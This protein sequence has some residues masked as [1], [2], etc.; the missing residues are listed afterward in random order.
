[1]S[2]FTCMVVL[3]ER[4]TKENQLLEKALQPFHEFECTGTNDEYVQEIDK[5]PEAREAFEKATAVLILQR[6]DGTKFHPFNDSGNWVDEVRPF[7]VEV[8]GKFNKQLVLPEGWQELRDEPAKEWQDFAAWCKGEYGGELIV[9]NAEPDKDGAHKYGW[10]RVVDG[11]VAELIDRTNPNKK[12]DWWVIGGRWKGLLSVKDDNDAIYGQTGLM[13]S[14]ADL[15]GADGCAVANLDFQAMKTK[16]QDMRRN[17]VFETIKDAGISYDDALKTWL[18]F[19]DAKPADFEA[20]EAQRGNEDG[21]KA[22]A[23]WIDAMTDD[24]PVKVFY[25]GPLSNCWGGWGAGIPETCRDPKAWIEEAPAISCYAMLIDGEWNDRGEMGWFGISS[26]EDEAR[27][28]DSEFSAK[29]ESLAPEKWVVVVD[30][31]I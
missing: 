1:M 5:L 17:S 2:H 22:Y 3:D 30:C 6:P 15:A 23:A 8:E 14:H 7:Y 29:L 13:G 26:G 10:C 31:H 28:W 21:I 16:Q 25:R 20:F 19:I 9:G 11:E 4:P 24:H 18:A 12:W 27:D